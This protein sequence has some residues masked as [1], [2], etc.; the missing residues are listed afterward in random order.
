MPFDAIIST[1]GGKFKPHPSTY[2]KA[3]DVLGV[4]AEEILHVAGSGSDAVGAT[5]FG[6]RTVWVNRAGDAVLDHRFAPAHEVSDLR[7]ILPLLDG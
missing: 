6:L 3:L 5:A 1:E 7:R 4:R 2:R